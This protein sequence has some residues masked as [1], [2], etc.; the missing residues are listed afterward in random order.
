[1]TQGMACLPEDNNNGSFR[2][3]IPLL[4][5]AKKLA[6]PPLPR[7]L[8]RPR[9]PLA[10][11]PLRLARFWGLRRLWRHRRAYQTDRGGA[12]ACSRGA[13]SGIDSQSSCAAAGV[14]RNP[15]RGATLSESRN[16]SRQQPLAHLTHRRQGGQRSRP[17]RVRRGRRCP[18][19]HAQAQ[20]GRPAQRRHT[21]TVR[22][23]TLHSVPRGP[24]SQ[25]AAAPAPAASQQ[26]QGLPAPPQTRPS[27]QRVQ[28]P[29]GAPWHR[30]Q[31]PRPRWVQGAL[32]E[33]RCHCWARQKH[34]ARRTAPQSHARLEPAAPT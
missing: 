14:C 33:R 1:M 18:G 23:W 28:V 4:G 31:R 34:P 19:W 20:Q 27:R 11:P 29:W 12:V 26:A 24:C 17:R 16:A 32:A 25:A 22:R 21:A 2:K 9:L 15:C 7:Q 13:K 10:R 3:G 8:P 30:R 5:L 6:A